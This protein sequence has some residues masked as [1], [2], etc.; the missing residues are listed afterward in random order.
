[1]R[2]GL[3]SADA[4]LGVLK[5]YFEVGSFGSNLHQNRIKFVPSVEQ[6][7][8]QNKNERNTAVL[9]SLKLGHGPART[10][11]TLIGTT[12]IAKPLSTTAPT[13]TI[14]STNALMCAARPKGTS[15]LG[16][17]PPAKTSLPCHTISTHLPS[18]VRRRRRVHQLRSGR[19]R[20]RH[21]EHSFLMRARR[22]SGRNPN[23]VPT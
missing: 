9:R 2:D 23:H 10:L 11:A 4:C 17:P 18:H 15:G 16:V 14:L 13:C 3:G 8:A 6:Q 20:R 12:L 7:R 5:K 22:R 1:M 21:R 19:R